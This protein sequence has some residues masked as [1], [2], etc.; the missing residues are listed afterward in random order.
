MGIIHDAPAVKP[1]AQ[2]SR[3]QNTAVG[4]SS[5]PTM[6]KIP[7]ETSAPKNPQTLDRWSAGDGDGKALK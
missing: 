4:S 1:P 3:A 2:S 7:I 5:R 6:S